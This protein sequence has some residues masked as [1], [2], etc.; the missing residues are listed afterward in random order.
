MNKNTIERLKTVHPELQRRYRILE[1]RMLKKYG[2]QIEVSDA[3]RTAVRQEE[4][5]AQ[6]RT[7]PGKK[8]TNARAWQSNH[9]YGIA[10]DVWPCVNGKFNWN[11]SAW[12]MAQFGEEVELLGLEWGG[13]WKTIVDNPHIQLPGL[14]DNGRMKPEAYRLVQNANG[15]LAEVWNYVSNQLE[16]L[17]P[18]ALADEAFAIPDRP[19]T[20]ALP[21]IPRIPAPPAPPSPQLDPGFDWREASLPGQ[22]ATPQGWQDSPQAPTIGEKAPDAPTSLQ[23]VFVRL[24]TVRTRVEAILALLGITTTGLSTWADQHRFQATIIA[25]S[26]LIIYTVRYIGQVQTDLAKMQ[27]AANPESYTVR[28]RSGLT[29]KDQSHA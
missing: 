14:T 26:A 23:T 3:H 2:I 9:N 13:R 20:A 12:M 19:A 22:V 15:S 6:G 25:A 27:Y 18:D 21:S 24:S 28:E 29:G 7:A 8:V 11:P 1:Q 5:F 16:P 10:L 17:P 4:L